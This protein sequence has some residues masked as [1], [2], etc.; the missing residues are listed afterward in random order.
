MLP[1]QS[2]SRFVSK[3]TMIPSAY[4][5]QTRQVPPLAALPLSY[6]PTICTAEPELKLNFV[7]VEPELPL[8]DFFE[9]HPAASPASASTA[10]TMSASRRWFC[11]DDGSFLGGFRGMFI[12]RI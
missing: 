4:T 12:S 8:D 6:V 3:Y 2:P 7:V 10:A 1:E 11:I 9:P 5:I